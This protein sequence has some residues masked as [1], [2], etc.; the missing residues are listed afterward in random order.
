MTKPTSLGPIETATHKPWA[1]WVEFLDGIGAQSL[2][3]TE[4]AQHAHDQMPSTQASRSWWAQSVAVAYEQY[5]GRRQPGQRSDG[6]YEA[7]VSKTFA[8]NMDQAMDAWML[9]VKD[10]T[11]FADVALAKSPSV[12]QTEKRRHWGVRLE[13]SS[14]VSVDAD[15]AA[16]GKSRLALTH[17]KLK[18][19]ESAGEW[20]LFWK[21]FLE[22]L[23]EQ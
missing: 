23:K 7:T 14:R 6:T 19:K 2:S 15:S 5:I 9:L 11:E 21:T 22:N 18:T 16:T 8:G 17:S 1:E 20:R 13:D 3:H 12:T 10:R 4:I